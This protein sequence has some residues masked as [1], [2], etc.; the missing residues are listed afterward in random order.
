[1]IIIEVSWIIY[2]I[3]LNLKSLSTRI[4]AKSLTLVFHVNQI[5][6]LELVVVEAG[7]LGVLVVVI[8]WLLLLS[9]FCREVIKAV[10]EIVFVPSKLALAVGVTVITVESILVWEELITAVMETTLRPGV[11]RSETADTA[12][13]G[14]FISIGVESGLITADLVSVELVIVFT[15]LEERLSRL[16]LLRERRAVSC[17][18][19]I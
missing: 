5:W 8:L 9:S 11:S 3:V 19:D 1:M 14:K 7:L 12:K 15:T 17:V 13:P 6:I 4:L 18:S 2:I 16:S 10:T